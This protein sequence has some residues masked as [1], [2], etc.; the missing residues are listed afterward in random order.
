MQQIPIPE[1]GLG[2][3]GNADPEQ[4]AESVRTALEMNY[5]HVDTAQMYD[6]EEYVGRGYAE[7][8]LDR[9]DVFLATKVHPD[10]LAHDD[11]LQTTESSLE[12]LG[13]DYVDLLYVHW[14]TSTYDARDTLPAF[15]ELR[16]EGKVK[17]V[18]VSNFTGDLL[19]EARDH[20]E[21]PILANQVEMHPLLQQ[22]ELLSYAR[23]HGMYLVAYAP[24]MQGE[25]DEVPELVEIAEKHGTSAAQ[26]SL[27]WLLSKE[28]VVPIPKATGRDHLEENFDARSLELDR[29]D[30]EKIEGIN[31]ER[32]LVDPDDAPWNW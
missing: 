9:D 31:R 15:D 1:P 28:E 8:D 21:S 24:M 2:T 23:E 25:A 22:D 11:V 18:G 12:R 10:H 27:A 26:V 30:L 17:H 7:S 5:R 29:D 32:R 3:S 6:N 4:C 19:D 13:V 14:P 20:L 16:D